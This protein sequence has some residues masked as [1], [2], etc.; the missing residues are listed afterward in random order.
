MSSKKSKHS[1]I[2]DVTDKTEKTNKTKLAYK[3]QKQN[4]VTYYFKKEVVDLSS[5]IS[6]F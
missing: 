4:S 3:E 5:E 6:V 1:Y 2:S